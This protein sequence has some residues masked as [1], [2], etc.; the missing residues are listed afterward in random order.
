MSGI[1]TEAGDG[2]WSPPTRS[3]LAPFHQA[4]SLLFVNRQICVKD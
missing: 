4:V 3:S 1:V 2:I